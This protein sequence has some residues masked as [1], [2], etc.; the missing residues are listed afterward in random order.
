MVP[1]AFCLLLKRMK[2]VNNDGVMP[3]IIGSL[4]NHEDDD[5][6]NPQI[7]I[8]DTWKTVFLHAL[9]VY[10]SSFDIL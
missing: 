7:C 3:V 9:H 5:N 8:F 2:K 1:Y 6:K 10:I 4:R